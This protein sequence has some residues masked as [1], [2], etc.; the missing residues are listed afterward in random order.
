MEIGGELFF[1]SWNAED[2]DVPTFRGRKQEGKEAIQ[3]LVRC[4]WQITDGLWL[5]R[6][7]VKQQGEKFRWES[8]VS[9]GDVYKSLFAMLT[10]FSTEL[11]GKKGQ[12][13]R[14]E[15]AQY[16]HLQYRLRKVGNGVVVRRAMPSKWGGKEFQILP[17]FMY[18]LASRTLLLHFSKIWS[19][20]DAA[21]LR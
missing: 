12:D 8:G 13:W 19:L 1:E 2:R 18:D 6:T 16:C 14:Q 20:E 7:S 9:G 17:M 21:G 3:E 15:M 5:G 11:E 4:L 10:Q